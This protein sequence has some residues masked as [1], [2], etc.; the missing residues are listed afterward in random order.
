MFVKYLL[1]G[2]LMIKAIV[3]FLLKIRISWLEIKGW[4]SLFL[5]LFYEYKWSGSIG[6]CGI[7][8]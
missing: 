4:L 8:W 2:G 7:A 3:I 1:F 6:E 5:D